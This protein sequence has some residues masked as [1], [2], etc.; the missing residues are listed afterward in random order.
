MVSGTNEAP[1]GRLTMDKPT[2]AKPTPARPSLQLFLLRALRIAASTTAIVEL[3]RN[4]WTG[5]TLAALAWVVF[6]L[7]DKL[8]GS[9]SDAQNNDSQ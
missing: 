9:S 7:V 6:L 4:D 8:R 2:P 3:L 1:A 5:G